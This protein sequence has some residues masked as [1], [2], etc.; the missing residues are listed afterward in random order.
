MLSVMNI[1]TKSD[2]KSWIY[3]IAYYQK[4]IP[5]FSTLAKPI[6]E[7]TTKNA[8][9]VWTIKHQES[10]DMLKNALMKDVVIAL[11]N[12]NKPFD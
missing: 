7:L 4:F 1:D 10:M 3:F 5:H 12:I 2:L 8:K 11:P 9:I 6:Y